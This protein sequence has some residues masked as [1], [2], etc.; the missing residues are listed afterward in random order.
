MLELQQNKF[1]HANSSL[2]LSFCFYVIGLLC[3][4]SRIIELFSDVLDGLA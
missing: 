1:S 2:T 4:I 3:L